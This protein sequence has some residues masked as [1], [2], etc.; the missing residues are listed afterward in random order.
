MAR[1]WRQMG[2]SGL[3]ALALAIAMPAAG[4]TPELRRAADQLEG[5][6]L[7]SC[8]GEDSTLDLVRRAEALRAA[9]GP[10]P[11]WLYAA[12]P[13]ALQWV[14][15]RQRLDGDLGAARTSYQAWLDLAPRN[16]RDRAMMVKERAGLEA[17]SQLRTAAISPPAPGAMAWESRPIMLADGRRA[18][19][20]VWV[21]AHCRVISPGEAASRL[22]LYEVASPGTVGRPRGAPLE[23]PDELISFAP[24][25]PLAYLMGDGTPVLVLRAAVG[26]QCWGCNRLRLIAA[27]KD[28][29]K[30]LPVGEDASIVPFAI[31][32]VG[33]D[34]RL[35]V[36]ASDSRWEGFAGLCPSCAPVPT[37]V[38]RWRE[39][40][41]AETC[42]EEHAFYERE[43]VNTQALLGQETLAD[44]A[45]G[46]AVA[47]LLNRLQQGDGEP[48]W[49]S[50]VGD[51]GRLR[52]MPGASQA[53]IE[54]AVRDLRRAL[55]RAGPALAQRGCPVLG[56]ELP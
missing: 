32:D 44:Y 56:L 43:T 22:V 21:S 25:R 42:R 10:R 16:H 26:G 33:Q 41:L 11:G 29:L 5:E 46:Q 4:Q 54:A 30:E 39:G 9:A 24:E 13:T 34:G 35:A 50:F 1:A 48:A 8:A 27:G 2:W 7:A 19:A 40:R 55:D 51:L 3:L 31:E 14:A 15:R 52:E 17:E 45:L 28:G 20:V 23:Y 49:D 47:L 6:V 12:A 37:L 36:L 38:Y 18:L 53:T